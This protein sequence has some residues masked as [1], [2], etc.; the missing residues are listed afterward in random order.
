MKPWRRSGGLV[1]SPPPSP[2][3]L[4]WHQDTLS[5]SW[6]WPNAN[7]PFWQFQV[8]PLWS[9]VIF[10]LGTDRTFPGFGFATYRLVGL[11]GGLP[12]T[13]YSNVV[14]ASP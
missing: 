9:N 4:T 5:W 2:L 13:P 10:T 11:S 3:V 12:V 8:S 6:V 7:P 14:L 1:P